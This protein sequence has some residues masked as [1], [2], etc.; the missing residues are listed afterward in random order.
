MSSNPENSYI[1]KID[2]EN[3][4]SEKVNESIARS[5]EKIVIDCLNENLKSMGIGV[6]PATPSEDSGIK[7][8]GGKQIDAVLNVGGK[9]TMCMQITT[10]RDPDVQRKKLIQLKE[11][12]FVRLEKMDQQETPIPKVIININQEEVTSFLNDPY[13]SHHPKIW[14]KIKNDI[15][16]SLLYV[17]N[18]TKNEKEKAKARELL[19]LLAD[20]TSTFH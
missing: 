10:A 12:P 2:T 5:A 14:A 8:E 4:P 3:L 18:I 13:F 11:N 6:R 9:A 15:T 7:N 1:K 20:N 17:L 16:N 19:T